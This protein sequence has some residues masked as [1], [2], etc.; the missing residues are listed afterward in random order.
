MILSVPTIIEKCVSLKHLWMIHWKI[1]PWKDSKIPVQQIFIDVYEASVR[2]PYGWMV[3]QLI[4]MHVISK[5]INHCVFFC[6]LLLFFSLY[7][8]FL[9]PLNFLLNSIK[10]Q[11]HA[12]LGY[13]FFL[14]INKFAGLAAL[15][16]LAPFHCIFGSVFQQIKQLTWKDINHSYS[17][18]CIKYVHSKPLEQH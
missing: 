1:W 7:P 4:S 6:L 13:F 3:G 18:G 17:L 12:K 16:R 2:L 10:I 11:K 8:L 15:P 5:T 14:L 9:F